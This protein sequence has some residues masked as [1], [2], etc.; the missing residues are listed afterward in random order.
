MVKHNQIQIIVQFYLFETAN[1]LTAKVQRKCSRNH[2]AA[3]RCIFS[4]QHI[5]SVGLDE[6]CSSK[7]NVRFGDLKEIGF[8]SLSVQR[9][10][11][12]QKSV[13]T[14]LETSL[15]IFFGQVNVIDYRCSAIT[16]FGY[17][18]QSPTTQYTTQGPSIKDVIIFQG[19]RGSY[20]P[21][22][23]DIRRQKLGK[24]GSKFRHGGGGYQKWPKNF[25]RLLWTATYDKLVTDQTFGSA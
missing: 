5:C 17:I 6:Q 2:N 12:Q 7:K 16:I 4:S 8:K 18:A 20:F 25:R 14:Q 23:L 15:P 22:L 21:M 10:R 1:I 9:R 13:A 19:G 3:K 24:S 11:K